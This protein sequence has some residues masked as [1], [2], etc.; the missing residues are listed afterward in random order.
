[1]HNDNVDEFDKEMDPVP[2]IFPPLGAKS[3][4]GSDITILNLNILLC[5]FKEKL[6][7][8]GR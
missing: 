1:M 5:A 7:K 2:L 8:L 6:F 3:M 4:T